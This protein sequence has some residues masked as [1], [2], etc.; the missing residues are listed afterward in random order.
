ML[1]VS[2]L[3]YVIGT[4]SLVGLSTGSVLLELVYITYG[5]KK[6]PAFYIVTVN[7]WSQYPA[8]Y[9]TTA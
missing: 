6:S 7:T 5:I 3:C 4:A 9:V 1:C 2:C 8:G